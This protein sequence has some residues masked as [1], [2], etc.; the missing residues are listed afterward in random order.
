M[1]A[2]GAG[3][4]PIPHKLLTAETLAAAIQSV[5]NDA[6]MRNRAAAIGSQIRKENGVAQA[7]EA[8]QHHMSAC[9]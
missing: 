5:T 9:A 8:F 4:R 2:L 1:F 6:C 3:P 7:V